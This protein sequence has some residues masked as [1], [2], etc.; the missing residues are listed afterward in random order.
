M[1]SKAVPVK[2]VKEM[3]P[4]WV[5]I[6]DGN[7]R[8]QLFQ[9]ELRY[10]GVNYVSV[11]YRRT[12]GTKAQIVA[13]DNIKRARAGKLIAYLVHPAKDVPVVPMPS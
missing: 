2:G 13:L 10:A 11:L 9:L 5:Y 12:P 4:K 1:A 8:V 6:G 3:K 7:I